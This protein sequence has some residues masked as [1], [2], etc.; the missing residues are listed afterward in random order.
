MAR[1]DD[2]CSFF[3]KQCHFTCKLF[4]PNESL[5]SV[6]NRCDYSML[7]N[8]FTLSEIL[9]IS[10]GD[11]RIMLCPMD[12][13]GQAVSHDAREEEATPPGMSF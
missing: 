7:N 5:V 10:L 2:L 13:C 6:R 11:H 4:L 8:L 9:S 12:A 1:E 3:I